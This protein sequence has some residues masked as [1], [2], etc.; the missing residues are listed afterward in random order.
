MKLFQ[1]PAQQP[2][3]LPDPATIVQPPPLA[4]CLQCGVQALDAI[5]TFCRRC[6]LPYGSPPRAD[7]DLPSCPICYASV[8]E[9]GRMASRTGG[10]R[11]DLVG[12]IEEHER[13]PVGDDDFLETL[14][15]GDRIR[16][17]RF[18]AP[19]DLVRR[20][21]VTGSL[22]GGRRRAAQ[23]DAIVTAMAQVARWGPN[24]TV[25]GDQAE[26]REAREAVSR[27]MERYARGAVP[28]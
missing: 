21:L 15:E 6:G 4:T 26:W 27:L 3:P 1:R 10:G 16:I 14:R 13:Y 22:D 25:F 19:F 28:R 9:D 11:L 20:Y 5:T 17:G 18:V 12:H 2:V 7:A 23:H 8:D 24:P